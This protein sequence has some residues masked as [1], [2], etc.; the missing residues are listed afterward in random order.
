MSSADALTG[1]VVVLALLCGVLVLTLMRKGGGR[2]PYR[3][4]EDR[5]KDTETPTR[6]RMVRGANE[7]V[8]ADLLLASTGVP[9]EFF[10]VG[11]LSELEALGETRGFVP[12]GML[13]RAVA[14][15]GALKAGMAAAEYSGRLVLVDNKTAAAIRAGSMMRDAA[16]EMVAVVRGSGGRIS[17]LTR[18]KTLGGTAATGAV[19]LPAAL[20]ALAL[21]A[22]LARMEKAIAGVGEEVR[23]LGW[24]FDA[25]RASRVRATALTLSEG[26]RV[27]QAAGQLDEVTWQQLAPLAHVIFEQQDYARRTLDR[28]VH[29]LHGL[30]TSNVHDR[31]EGLG[32]LFGDQL[33]S[34]IAELAETNRQFLQFQAL[35]IW[36]L[37][38][39]QSRALDSHVAEL[40]KTLAGQPNPRV[41]RDEVLHALESHPELS[42]WA[43]LMNPIDKGRLRRSRDDAYR[44]IEEFAWSALTM[45]PPAGSLNG[46]G[47]AQTP[48]EARAGELVCGGAQLESRTD[49]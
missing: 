16:G 3:G 47:E 38:D 1:A 5:D 6:S 34:A 32:K 44:F 9:D 12:R 28:L 14:L 27:S 20:S 45:T 8:S 42:A 7:G 24:K 37:S 48:G 23:D 49:G 33:P 15:D 17:D 2:R 29:E 43:K 40:K 19:A 41:V 30:R 22:Q 10:A 46:S 25:A 39:T 21:Q 18:L 11:R 36:R 35:R 26:Y 4:T 31:A 13:D